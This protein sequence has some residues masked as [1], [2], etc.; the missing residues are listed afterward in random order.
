M[1]KCGLNSTL[2]P[3]QLFFVKR[4][5]KTP[6]SKVFPEGNGTDLNNECST[7]YLLLQIGLKRLDW[8]LDCLCLK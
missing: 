6:N 5:L 3:V 1:F 4:A 2:F 8:W 7:E